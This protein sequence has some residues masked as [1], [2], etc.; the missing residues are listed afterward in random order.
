MPFVVAERGPNSWTS[1]QIEY[2]CK[3][4]WIAMNRDGGN[5]LKGTDVGGT[6]ITRENRSPAIFVKFFYCSRGEAFFD[7]GLHYELK[8][9]FGNYD[10]VQTFPTD[11]WFTDPVWAV[12]KEK[13]N[14]EF[15]I[16]F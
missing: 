6:V 8:K 12:V 2:L 10:I 15:D 3:E 16:P 14:S 5:A 11:D 9:R 13:D 4:A 1:G 7:R